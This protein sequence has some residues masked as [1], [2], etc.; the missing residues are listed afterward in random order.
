MNWNGYDEINTEGE[1]NRKNLDDEKKNLNS[2]YGGV[3]GDGNMNDFLGMVL[4]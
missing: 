1:R 2:S 3:N 4:T